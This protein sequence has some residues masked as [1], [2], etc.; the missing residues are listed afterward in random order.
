[1]LKNLLVEILVDRRDLKV[2]EV[3]VDLNEIAR[4]D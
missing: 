1:L 3:R 4:T 2:L